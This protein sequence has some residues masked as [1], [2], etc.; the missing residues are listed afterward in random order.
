MARPLDVEGAS[1]RLEAVLLERER[2]EW[3]VRFFGGK[4]CYVIVATYAYEAVAIAEQREGISK[5]GHTTMC[6]GRTTA[7]ADER[8]FR[9]DVFAGF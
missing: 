7:P 3:L 4:V 2:F 1:Q 6:M 9:S 8:Q 5:A